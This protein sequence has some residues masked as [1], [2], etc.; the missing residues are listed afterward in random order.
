IQLH[1]L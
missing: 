1:Q